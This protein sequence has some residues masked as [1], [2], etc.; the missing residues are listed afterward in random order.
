MSEKQHE[1]IALE[2]AQSV[3]TNNKQI[4]YLCDSDK[5]ARLLK[6][7]LKLFMDDNLIGY[8][9]ER[10]ILPYDRFSTA[11]SIV[12]ERIN[13]LNSDKSNFKIIIT[14]CI[15]LFE[16]LPSKDFFV[17]R[18][19]Y[20][21][22]DSLS[23]KDLTLSLEALNYER[24]DK[25]DAINQYTVRG[26][27]VDF[28]SGFQL[29]PIRVDF[30]GDQIDDIREFDPSSQNMTN[31]LSEF[32]LFS[33]SEVQLDEESIGRFKYAWRNYFQ[34]YDERHCEIFQSLASGKYLEGYEI[35]NPLIQSGNSNLVDYFAEFSLIKPNKIDQILT[36]YLAFVEERYLEE[37]IDSSRPILKPKDYIFEFEDLQVYLKSADQ[38]SLSDAKL[39][40][41]HSKEKNIQL[42]MLIDKQ[43][44]GII[45]TL[46]VTSSEQTKLDQINKQYRASITSLPF[47]LKNGIFSCMHLPV[48]SFIS[49]NGKFVHLNLDEILNS[50]ILSPT[51]T[52]AN[53]DSLIE[54]FEN[55]FQDDELVIHVDYGVGI[56]K[57]LELL[58]TNSSEE[59]YIRIEYLENEI[60]YVP[61]RQAYLVSKFQVSQTHGVRLDSLSSAKWKVKKEKAKIKARDHAAELLDIE[62]RRSVATSYQL[63][64]EQS[65]YQE[66]DKDFPYVLT[67]DQVNCIK[68]ILKDMA[69]V[70][71]MNRVICGDVGFGK[72][73]VAMRGAFVG[74]H[75]KKQV[76]V[77]APSTVL[78]K[79]HLESFT[80]RF[81][82]FPV[83]IELLTRHTSLKNKSKIYDDFKHGKIDILIGTHALLNND[84]SLENLGLL[85]IDEEHRFGIKQKEIIKSRQSTTHILY[86]SATPIPRTLNLVYSGL[87]DFS[88]LYTP[89]LERLSVR[90]FLNTQNQQ[91]I[92][93]AIDRELARG[94]QVF[95]V[96]NNISKM[97]GLKNQIKNLV[98]EANIDIAHGKLSKKDITNT[99]NGFN[100][101]SIDILICT[102]IVEMGLDIPNANTIIV[103]DAHNF[104]LSQLHQLRGRVGRSMRQAYCYLLIPTQDLKKAP[105]AKLDSLVKYSDLGSGYF[106]AQEDLEIRGAGDF[107]GVKQSGHIEAI[108]LSMYLSMLKSA[109]NDLKGHKPDKILDTEI[110]FNDRALI[111]DTYLPVANER[112]KI[113]RSLNDARSDEEIDK[114][115][116]ELK[117]RCG[118]PNDDLLNLIE[119]SKLRILANKVGIKK[120]YSNL[121]NAMITFNNNLSDQVY[122]KL[123]GLIQTGSAKIKLDKEN[124]I[125]LDVSKNNNKRIA[126]AGLLNE[127]V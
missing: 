84:I 46:L 80:K 121:E 8:Y 28:Y 10:E 7:E 59:E 106:I 74:V 92:K 15:N 111:P 104:G 6:N 78:A 119:S 98:P 114:I 109:V 126:V 86:M 127:L 9:P 77:L 88:Y 66:F 49:T 40:I 67:S 17:A 75:A 45:D 105:Q 64:C 20:K 39:T 4:L 99:M 5:E 85:I 100:S 47:T 41:D 95:L 56:Y 79:Q 2:L 113:Y 51:S 21:I 36:S 38:M 69:L 42:K 3:K 34:S 115:L 87:K 19:K 107:L 96:Q 73:E 112:L 12:Q 108:G 93:N 35:Y 1:P 124:K 61:I 43:V 11:D 120:I 90:T 27:V 122:K 71:P 30:F 63:I 25:V 123:I 70:K 31:K 14:S 50:E 62:S 89:P 103:I 117:D 81:V 110:N 118:K 18:K 22:Y 102:T 101:N 33:G 68:D 29:Q 72:T 91:I 48:R 57:G 76:M 32:Q 60:L 37:S 52:S 125:T 116:E 53:Q 65:S 94:G 16:K 44:N 23:I 82:N 13:L 26:G 54:N 58:K 55:P 83:N 97:E 24:T